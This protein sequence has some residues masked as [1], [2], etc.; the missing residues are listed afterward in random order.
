M[1]CLEGKEPLLSSPKGRE[2]ER[3]VAK[4]CIK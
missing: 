2:K 3:I 1:K 4:M